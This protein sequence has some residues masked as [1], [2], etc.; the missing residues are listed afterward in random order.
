MPG[1]TLRE[2]AAGVFVARHDHPSIVNGVNA[3]IVAGERGLILVDTL[4]SPDSART[5]LDAARGG[6]LGGPVVAVINTHDHYDHVLGNTAFPG[7]PVHAHENAAAL[8][9]AMEPP[10]HVGHPFSSVA[11]VDLGDRLIEI[12]HP[13]RG[14][15]AG[16]AVVRASTTDGDVL[17]AGDLVEDGAPPAYGE[18]SYPLEWPLALD[19]LETILDS[20]SIVVPG[21]GDVVDKEYVGD[22]RASI[23]VV[24]ETIRDLA[25]RGVPVAQAIE[26]AQWPFPRESLTHAIPLGYAQLPRSARSLPLI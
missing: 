24:A 7:V 13:G 4:W 12:L 18:D 11:T 14:H 10:L 8:M 19:F 2:V 20:S 3:G 22:Q 9:E 21:H 16:D 6:G 23:G 17:F 26:A 25:S 5:L 1:G 15:T